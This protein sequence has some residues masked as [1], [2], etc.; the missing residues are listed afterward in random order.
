VQGQA[1]VLDG[2]RPGAPRAAVAQGGDDLGDALGEPRGHDDL[3]GRRDDAPRPAEVAGERVPQGRQ[4]ARVAVAEGV[5]RGGVEHGPQR[6]LPLLAGEAGTQVEQAGQQVDPHVGGHVVDDRRQH[7]R[8]HGRL[9][10]RRGAPG[11]RRD[12]RGGARAGRQVALGHQ[13]G[14]GVDDR[15]AGDAQL[16]GERPRGRHRRPGGQAPVDDR[17]AQRLLQL[18]APAAGAVEVDAQVDVRRTG[19]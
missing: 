6:R 1:R 15:A 11:H 7:R 9:G 13:L 2:D 18:G 5:V 16:V 4:A 8:Q 19:P 14:I 17:L 3:V 12:D 10:P